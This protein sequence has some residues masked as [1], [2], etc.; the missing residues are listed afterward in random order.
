MRV[1]FCV[2]PAFAGTREETLQIV[3]KMAA[4]L[5]SGDAAGFLAPVDKSL[6]D[7]P[8]LRDN[9]YALVAEAEATSSIEIIRTTSDATE[10]DWYLELRS[11]VTG[12]LAERRREP[13][14]VQVS[15]GKIQSLKPVSFFAPIH[16][17]RPA[18][19]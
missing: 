11:R 1:P 13:V 4:S 5:S 10:L 18:G 16:V 8:L 7:F 14:T 12:S 6:A 17:Q 3:S 15:R 2:F 9:V 19:A